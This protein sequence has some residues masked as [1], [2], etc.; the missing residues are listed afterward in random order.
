M[1]LIFRL[2]AVPG[3]KLP[4]GYATLGHFVV[5]AGLG[6]LLVLPLRRSHTPG[7]A[8]ALAVLVASIYG[9]TD[10]FHQAFVPMRTPD[11]ADWGV[12]TLGACVGALCATW[13][14]GRV[15]RW[16]MRRSGAQ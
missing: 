5:Y 8:V 6:A 7:T 14:L 2:S 12:D 9:V 4:G 15:G 13:L 10:E 11:I 1:A 3:S 16:Q